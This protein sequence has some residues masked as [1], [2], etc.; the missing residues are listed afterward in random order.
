MISILNYMI[1][2]LDVAGVK[3]HPL[4]NTNWQDQQIYQLDGVAVENKYANKILRNL[5]TRNAA[6][7]MVDNEQ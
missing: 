4:V 5:K 1:L 2:R 3:F 7:K 6:Y